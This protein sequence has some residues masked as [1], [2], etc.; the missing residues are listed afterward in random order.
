MKK[1]L[2]I[3]LSCAMLLVLFSACSSG[4]A[5][6]TTAS[7]TA[8]AASTTAA[9]TAVS[10]ESTTG[11]GYTGEGY[12]IKYDPPVTV[13]GVRTAASSS[14]SDA[15]LDDNSW[16]DLYLERHGIILEY[17]WVCDSTQYNEKVNMAIM[18]GEIPDIMQVNDQQY[19]QLYEAEL[20][21]NV[22]S[23]FYDYATADTITCTTEQG[24]LPYEACKRDGV[25]YAIPFVT[26][27]KENASVL[28]LR[29]DWMNQTGSPEPSNLANVEQILSDF[30]S[31][32]LGGVDYAICENKDLGFFISVICPMFDGAYNIWLEKDGE[33]VYGAVQSEIRDALTQ[34]AAWYQAGFIDPE[35]ITNDGSKVA[36]KIAAS[37]IGINYGAF[38]SPLSGW[39]SAAQLDSNIEMSYYPIPTV[40]GDMAKMPIGTGIASYW[41]AS[42]D[43]EHPEAITL[44]IN[45]FIE[46][47]YM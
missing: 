33:L 2:A 10:T 20:L 19:Q 13:T 6:S 12:S 24:E 26:L 47:F 22:D 39:T 46:K 23:A 11:K 31:A 38:S 18:S 44:M 35:M 30:S 21:T 40:S 25:L 1:T 16:T 15:P 29:Q 36:E 17:L 32:Q 4:G 41:V 3:I 27:V 43:C 28:Y 7:T 37:Q 9:T 14:M 5:T 45:D 42:K 34:Y 8:A